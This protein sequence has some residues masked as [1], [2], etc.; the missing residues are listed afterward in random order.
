M[1]WE[2]VGAW[3]VMQASLRTR[4]TRPSPPHASPATDPFP[5]TEPRSE[6]SRATQLGGDGHR[7]WGPHLLPQGPRQVRD[8]RRQQR[9]QGPA[10]P[11]LPCPPGGGSAQ[12]EN[13]QCA[14]LPRPAFPS[15]LTIGCWG[16]PGLRREGPARGGG[17]GAGFPLLEAPQ[18]RV[19]TLFPLPPARNLTKRS[20]WRRRP[21][22]PAAWRSPKVSLPPARCLAF[23]LGWG[24]GRGRG[25]EVVL[26]R[27]SRTSSP[28]RG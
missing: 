26:V 7:A 28:G 17:A 11:S 4:E 24:G 22:P 8:T 18:Q 20:P 2:P 9:G 16:R 3:P 25:L 27:V 5:S 23:A 15:S 10:L 12:R 6:V 13:R 14:R 19:L 1:R 21:P